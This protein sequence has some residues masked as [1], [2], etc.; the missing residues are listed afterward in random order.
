MQ[1]IINHNFRLV[2]ESD[3]KDKHRKVFLQNGMK[4]KLNRAM[5][6][7]WEKIDVESLFIQ[8]FVMWKYQKDF[9]SLKDIHRKKRKG[10]FKVCNEQF[11]KTRKQANFYGG[12]MLLFN[13]FI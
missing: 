11:L 3:L 12:V 5:L 2:L 4:W 9:F 1:C 7:L 13:N 10:Y 8:K 6:F